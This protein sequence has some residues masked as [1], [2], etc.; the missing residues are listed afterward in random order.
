[1]LD[2]AHIKWRVI[3]I[4]ACY[5]GGY[6]EPLRNENTMVMTASDAT[7]TSF[8]CGTESDFTYF[9]R[10]LFDEELRRTTSFE[11][12][13]ESARTTI[14]R[15]E[16]AAGEEPSNPQIFVGPAIRAK[17]AAYEKRLA[18]PSRQVFQRATPPARTRGMRHACAR[19]SLAHSKPSPP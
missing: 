10:A 7:H 2:E 5:S 1:M 15:R 3:V 16:Q 19:R 9:G 17:L 14:A 13:F 8:G 6:V 11:R 18:T 4:S 12:A